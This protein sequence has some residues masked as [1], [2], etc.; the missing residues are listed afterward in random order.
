MTN[1]DNQ[2]ALGQFTHPPTAGLSPLPAELLNHKAAGCLRPAIA[3]AGRTPQVQPE[4]YR[5]SSRVTWMMFSFEIMDV[6]LMLLGLKLNVCTMYVIKL[7]MDLQDVG[8]VEGVLITRLT[9][10]G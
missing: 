2:S 6:T 3:S 7:E 10:H 8:F 9:R 4:Q 5:N 1:Q